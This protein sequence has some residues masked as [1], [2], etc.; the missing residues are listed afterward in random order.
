[1]FRGIIRNS[2]DQTEGSV[3][4]AISDGLD[5]VKE[6]PRDE[7][8]IAFLA[9][10]IV[11][12]SLDKGAIKYGEYKTWRQNNSLIFTSV[13]DDKNELIGFFHIFPLTPEAGAATVAGKL[14]ERSFTIDHIVPIES[15]SSVR[16]VHIA[17]ILV[18]PRQRSF[19]PLVAREL[20]LIK[21]ADFMQ[22]HYPPVASRVYTAYAQSKAGEALLRRSGFS[23]GVLASENVPHWP[24]YILRSSEAN[25]AVSRFQ[26]ARN[27]LS[28]AR[29]EHAEFK[30][31]DR[32]IEG[33]EL[34]LR[35]LISEKLGS[36]ARRLPSNISGEVDKR[37]RQAAK[38]M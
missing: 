12:R 2:R 22:S 21:M 24:L 9:N 25:P 20:V 11:R 16:Y 6:G 37:I 38:R 26:Q 13:I 32:R 27:G 29:H 31:L 35:G 15:I 7:E 19:S 36:D 33:I 28:A 8:A 34:Q 18:N 17:T 1:M 14:T 10:K 3:V 23:V 4:L 30:E 5:L